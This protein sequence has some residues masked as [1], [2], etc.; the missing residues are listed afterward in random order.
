L[1]ALAL[2]R[3]HQAGEGKQMRTPSLIPPPGFSEMSKTE[4]VRYLQALWD[5][6]AD[7]PGEIPVPDSHLEVA[8]ARLKR[9]REEPSS[10]LPSFAILDRLSKKQQ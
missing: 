7:S 1:A 6:I 3:Y 2:V 5:Q 10:G 9:Y 8:E 4:Q